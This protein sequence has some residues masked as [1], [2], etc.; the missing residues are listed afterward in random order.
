MRFGPP[1]A[2]DTALEASQETLGGRL[3]GTHRKSC[4]PRA[5]SPTTRWRSRSPRSRHAGSPRR[6]AAPQCSPRRCRR[7]RRCRCR[8]CSRCP[9]S[10]CSGSSG[11]PAGCASPPSATL[12]GCCCDGTRLARAPRS[13]LWGLCRTDAWLSDPT[14]QTEGCPATP[15][16]PPNSAGCRKSRLT[17]VQGQW[18]QVSLNSECKEINP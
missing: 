14:S 13:R 7:R 8:S 16:S 18:R 5:C 6:R 12:A 1:F 2:G 10:P 4:P 17:E 3:I 15:S 11:C 9:S